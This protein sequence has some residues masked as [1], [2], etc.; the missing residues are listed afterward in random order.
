MTDRETSIVAQALCKSVINNLH[1]D[2]WRDGAQEAV[3][4]YVRTCE[5]LEG[6]PRGIS[7]GTESRGS[8]ASSAPSPIPEGTGPG[9]STS[10]APATSLWT[11]EVVEG[12]VN[13]NGDGWRVKLAGDFPKGL[14]PKN[15]WIEL[16]DWHSSHGLAQQLRPGDRVT[17]EL[18]PSK[19][20]RYVNVAPGGL[21]RA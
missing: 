10:A 11:Y 13:R 9:V 3:Q 1:M 6:G 2:Q 21:Q 19:C 16:K 12:N 8:T 7:Q 4:L 5:L 17:L 20:G 14:R 18:Q 15:D